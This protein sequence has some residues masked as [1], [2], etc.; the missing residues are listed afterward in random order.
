M[1]KSPNIIFQAL[2]VAAAMVIP[3]EGQR[4]SRYDGPIIDMHLHAKTDV[5][6]E[7]RFCFPQ[8]CE[9]APTLA[10]SADDLKP[11]TLEAMARNNIVLGVVSETPEKVLPWTEAE[12]ERFLTGILVADPRRVSL[13]VLRELF[14]TGRAQVLGEITAQYEGIAI[15]DPLLD[16]LFAM[17]H[18]MD[19]PVLVHVLGIGGSPDFSSHL[20]NP[21]RLVPVLRKY[22]GLRVYLENAGWPFLEEVTSLMYQFPNVYAEHIDDPSPNTKTRR[23]Q[24]C[25]GARGE[26]PGQAHHVRI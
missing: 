4:P 5:G 25:E 19:I 16:P 2:A 20:G 18:E 26:W 23:A 21:L 17:A 13:D 7:R 24:I 8:P 6:R 12:G 9:G 22:P 10:K 11:M 1:K 15:D 14:T 3:A